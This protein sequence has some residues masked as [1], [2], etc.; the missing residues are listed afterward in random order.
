MKVN[1]GENWSKAP[2]PPLNACLRR[3][4]TGKLKSITLTRAGTV[5][6]D[7]SLLVEDGLEASMPLS[8]RVGIG[9]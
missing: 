7:A 6:Y 3:E 2:K 9:L 1:A 4:I 5:N 8:G